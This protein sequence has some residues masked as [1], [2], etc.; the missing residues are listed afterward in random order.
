[1]N[2]NPTEIDQLII[3]GEIEGAIKKIIAQSR[4]RCPSYNTINF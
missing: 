1:M 4:C 3:S 2:N